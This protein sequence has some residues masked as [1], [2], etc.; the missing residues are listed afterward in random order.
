MRKLSD[1]DGRMLAI[2]CAVLWVLALARN[3][4]GEV[5]VNSRA[6]HS[7]KASE[8]LRH[9][10]FIAGQKLT[11]TLSYVGSAQTNFQA[12]FEDKNAAADRSQPG[13]LG[14]AQSFTTTVQGQLVVTV[15]NVKD[16]KVVLAYNLRNAVVKLIAN[17]QEDG[18]D[19]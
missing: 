10:H 17:G 2:C 6:A 14:L 11:Y 5:R 1:P 8:A 16:H 7:S 15:V 12:L 18:A 3:G 13:P 19:A 9:Y 4:A